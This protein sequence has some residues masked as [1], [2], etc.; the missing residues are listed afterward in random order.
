MRM[1]A[2]LVPPD[3]V[4]EDLDAFLEPRREVAGPRWSPPPQWHVTLAFAAAV[5]SRVVE[6]LAEALGRAV[7]GSSVAPLRLAGGGCFPDPTRARV[8][9]AGVDGGDGLAALAGRVRSAF[10]TAGAAPDG[11]A[12]V[13]HVTV[14]RFGRP[15]EGTRWLRVLD[16]YVGPSWTPSEVV[17][18]ESHLPSERG[19][20]PRHEVLE[21]FAVL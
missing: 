21:R 18:V 11:G 8:L 19:H 5:P 6:P 17:L 10:A 9:W 3:D 4:V 1:F 12:F 20:R 7:A 15:V 14:A 13:P 2:A 16:T